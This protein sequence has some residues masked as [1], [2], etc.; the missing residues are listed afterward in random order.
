MEGQETLV[1]LVVMDSPEP[2][3]HLGSR[4]CLVSK[5]SEDFLDSQDSLEPQVF[6]ALKENHTREI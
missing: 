1:Y 5:E 3:E 2:Q 6:Q 4:A